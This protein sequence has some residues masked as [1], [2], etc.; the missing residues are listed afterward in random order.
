MAKGQKGGWL[1][2]SGRGGEKPSPFANEANGAKVAPSAY[3]LFT[4][5]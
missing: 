5:T 2:A 3:C 4:S 1:P